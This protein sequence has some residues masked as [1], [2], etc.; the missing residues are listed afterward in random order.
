MSSS[1]NLSKRDAAKALGVGIRQLE[2]LVADGRVR[3]VRQGRAHVFPVDSLF[4]ELRRRVAEAEQQAMRE[5]REA[6][7][8][9][10]LLT[11]AR[12]ELAE[13]EAAKRRGETVTVADVE[14]LVGELCDRL[15]AKLLSVPGGWAPRLVN[16]RTIAE[17]QQLLEELVR[18]VLGVLSTQVADEI[19]SAPLA[20]A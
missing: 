16:L 14:Q 12:R 5:D 18:E 17:A 10:V 2:R 20:G 15:R 19:E 1:M 11:R 9:Q 6:K 13:Y 8:E 7:G 4:R 3:L